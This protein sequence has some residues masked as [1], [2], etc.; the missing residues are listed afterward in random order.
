MHG[1]F[2]KLYETEYMSTAFIFPGQGSQSVGMGKDLYDNFTEAKE[3][4][5]EVDDALSVNLS[6]IIFEGPDTDL[7]LTE[8]TQPA[9]MAVSMAP[10]FTTYRNL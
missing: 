1:Y 9:L 3:V 6:K 7:N 4:F 2:R 5:Q 8:N 10:T